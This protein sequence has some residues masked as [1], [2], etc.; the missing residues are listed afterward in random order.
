[1]NVYVRVFVWTC[2]FISLAVSL[3]EALLGHMVIPP[4]FSFEGL[5][6]CFPKQPHHFTFTPAVCEG[7]NFSPSQ[8][9]FVIIH[10]FDSSH[11]S[12]YEVVSQGGFFLIEI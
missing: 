11:L 7:S 10:L 9:T 4:V 8:L 2:A 12:G 6:D 3:G 5:P 1:M